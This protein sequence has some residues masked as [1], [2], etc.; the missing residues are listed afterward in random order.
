MV[1]I[2]MQMQMLSLNTKLPCHQPSENTDDYLKI[3]E[4]RMLNIFRLSFKQRSN[5]KNSNNF[6][7]QT[8]AVLT[9]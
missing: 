9:D 8:K 3:E 6:K 1:S 4:R 2:E 5:I 7:N